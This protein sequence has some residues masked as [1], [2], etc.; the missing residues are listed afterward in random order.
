ML[1]NSNAS[2]T[3]INIT[4]IMT[5]NTLLFNF[6]PPHHKVIFNHRVIDTINYNSF[7]RKIS[8]L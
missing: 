3:A 8:T 1:V 5:R 4:T 6:N 2:T 7:T